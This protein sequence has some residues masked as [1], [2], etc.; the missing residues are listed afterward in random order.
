[1]AVTTQLD[2]A[3]PGV[4]VELEIVQVPVFE[5]VTLPVPEPPVVERVS[6]LPKATVAA[7][8]IVKVLWVALFIVMV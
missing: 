6:V 2:P 8:S 1:V 7:L 4:R 3:S 5:Y